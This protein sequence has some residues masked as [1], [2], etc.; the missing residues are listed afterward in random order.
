MDANTVNQWLTLAANLGV[1]AGLILVGFQIR[2]NTRITK[3]QITNDYYLADMELELV[4][5]G[6]QPIDPWV[7]SIYSPDKVTQADVAILDR[8]FNYGLVQ[9]Q[10]LRKMQELGL[11]DDDW[12]NGMSYLGW[13]LGNEIGRRWWKYSKSSYPTDFVKMVDDVLETRH[14]LANQNLL[15]SMLS[16]DD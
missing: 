8:Y 12:K 16:A 9:I 14:Y 11:A 5:M 15:N 4:M 6:E 13:H 2:Q 7:K 10:R 1:V 3:A